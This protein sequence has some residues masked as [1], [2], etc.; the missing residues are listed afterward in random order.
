VRRGVARLVRRGKVWLGYN[1]ENAELGNEESNR[2]GGAWHGMA[3][4]GAARYG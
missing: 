4:R 2:S 3:G 1:N